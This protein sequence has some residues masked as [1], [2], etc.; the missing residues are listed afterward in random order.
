[1]FC[2]F[3]WSPK[4]GKR[5]MYFT[6]NACRVNETNI[7]YLCMQSWS[8][9]YVIH[10]LYESH[11]TCRMCSLRTAWVISGESWCWM[12]RWRQLVSV[13]RTRGR[14]VGTPSLQ[15]GHSSTTSYRSGPGDRYGKIPVHEAEHL[16]W[17]P[18]YN[19][20]STGADSWSFD[21]SHTSSSHR[22]TRHISESGQ[23]NALSESPPP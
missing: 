19:I 23:D 15:G 16:L 4:W 3:I 5:L 13:T 11:M 22:A 1:M 18:L 8:C 7:V 2:K 9:L 10:H 20:V 14:R 6:S 21:W 17:L 12:G